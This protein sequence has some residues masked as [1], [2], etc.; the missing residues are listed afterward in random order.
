MKLSQLKIVCVLV[1]TLLVMSGL[2]GC[3]FINT[4][5]AKN[6][7]NNGA[8]SYGAGKYAEAQQFFERAMEIDPS[9]QNAAL[10]RARSIYAQYRTGIDT[11][12]NLKVAQDAIAA[13][14]DILKNDPTNDEAFNLIGALYGRL[15]E[16]DK[17]REWIVQR[18]KMTNIPEAKRSDAYTILANKNLTC[19]RT[20]TDQKENAIA[21]K[22]TG[23]VT[24][25]KPKDPKDFTSAQQ[26]V[27]E[28][29]QFVNEAVRLNDTSAAAWTAKTQLEREMAKL[30]EM[31]GKPDEKAKYIKQASEDEAIAQKYT[32]ALEEKK[33][34][35]EEAKAKEKN[36]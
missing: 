1:V 31:D 16:E 12:Q 30:S 21:D 15:K 34:Q 35:E 20:I 10:F 7:L 26:C 28:G 5:R 9:Q 2:S 6:E 22:N 11:P 24:F 19:S 25:R 14:Q 27:T 13:Y 29:L 3:G 36:S 17:Q 23:V 4:I 18:T 32:K 33:K 8:R